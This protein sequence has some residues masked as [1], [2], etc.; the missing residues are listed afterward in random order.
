MKPTSTSE[1]GRQCGATSPL[2][3]ASDLGPND[4]AMPPC[5][6][7]RTGTR[8]R[9]CCGSICRSGVDAAGR[10]AGP[11]VP[12]RRAS[13]PCAIAGVKYHGGQQGQSRAGEANRFSFH[14]SV[15]VERKFE[16]SDS[17]AMIQRTAASR[18]MMAAD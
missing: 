4:P 11:S 18:S 5:L 13:A 1:G 12:R 3:S 2:V 10:D 8:M 14:H 17:A 7:I 6:R 16:P 15:C 9:G